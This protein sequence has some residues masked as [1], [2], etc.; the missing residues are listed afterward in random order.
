[1][2]KKEPFRIEKNKQ[3]H[4][5]FSFSTLFGQIWELNFVLNNYQDLIVMVEVDILNWLFAFQ[6]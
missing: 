6:I 1:M 3:A 2:G 5:G 4:W